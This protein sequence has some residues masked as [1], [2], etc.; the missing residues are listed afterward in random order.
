MVGLCRD[1]VWKAK[2]QKDQSL[3]RDVENN[4]KGF[5]KSEKKGQGQYTHP[6]K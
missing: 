3:A 6:E 4:E 5:Y 1:A 2:A